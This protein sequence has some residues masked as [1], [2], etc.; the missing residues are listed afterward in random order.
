MKEAKNC[1][2]FFD[3]KLKDNCA[4]YQNKHG[5]NCWQTVAGLLR[6]RCI[7][8][9]GLGIEDCTKCAWYLKMKKGA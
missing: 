7:G 5:A 4:A 2:E 9:D 1:W 8:A 3:C 6:M